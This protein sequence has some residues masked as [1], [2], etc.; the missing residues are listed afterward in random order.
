SMAPLERYCPTSVAN[1]VLILPGMP[2]CSMATRRLAALMRMG[3]R[4]APDGRH[5]GSLDA[6]EKAPACLKGAGLEFDKRRDTCSLL[7]HHHPNATML[8]WVPRYSVRRFRF[9]VPNG[10]FVAHL[11]RL[12]SRP[13]EGGNGWQ[14]WASGMSNGGPQKDAP[15]NRGCRGIGV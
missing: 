13:P 11:A 3:R 6:E 8:H 1:V 15:A 12:A 7:P 9:T 2:S 4:R 5:R 10:A 14:G